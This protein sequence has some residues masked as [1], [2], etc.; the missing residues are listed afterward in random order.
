MSLHFEIMNSLIVSTEVTTTPVV[1]IHPSFSCVQKDILQSER[2]IIYVLV[3]EC[4]AFLVS[5]SDPTE[6][7]WS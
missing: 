3:G 1:Q 5:G 7:V 6:D 4:S 2:T